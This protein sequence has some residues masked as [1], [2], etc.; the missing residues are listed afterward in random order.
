MDLVDT[1]K[2][3]KT[4]R[5]TADNTVY[6][7]DGTTQILF[8]APRQTPRPTSLTMLGDAKFFIAPPSRR[9]QIIVDGTTVWHFAQI[10]AIEFDEDAARKAFDQTYMSP[11]LREA[12]RVEAAKDLAADEG[13][14][15][16]ATR[17][18]EITEV[19]PRLGFPAALQAFETTDE[20]DAFYA[21]DDLGK[22][23]TYLGGGVGYPPL[24]P[25]LDDD[26]TQLVVR[27]QNNIVGGLG[28]D[29]CHYTASELARLVEGGHAVVV[30]DRVVATRDVEKMREWKAWQRQAPF[31]GHTYKDVHGGVVVGSSSSSPVVVVGLAGAAHALMCARRRDKVRLVYVDVRGGVPQAVLNVVVHAA[32]AAGFESVVASPDAAPPGTSSV[33]VV[34]DFE[35]CKRDLPLL[36]MGGPDLAVVKDASPPAACAGAFAPPPHRFAKVVVDAQTLQDQGLVA[37]VLAAAPAVDLKRYFGKRLVYSC[38]DVPLLQPVTRGGPRV[39]PGAHVVV[40]DT[41]ERGR[42]SE[43]RGDVIYLAGRPADQWYSRGELRATFAVARSTAI[44]PTF[45]HEGLLIVLYQPDTGAGDASW[46]R[47]DVSA[48]GSG[49][50]TGR[51]KR[52][53]VVATKDTD[54]DALLWPRDED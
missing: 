4:F 14:K 20:F 48:I 38:G 8:G 32:L 1:D 50:E 28:D 37:A 3:W 13:S 53:L 17:T 39:M 34:A 44:A 36:G 52:M 49:V 35:A 40:N 15:W 11:E 31:A 19:F 42:V 12:Y 45:C 29:T 26:D 54:L 16:W 9:P 43:V 2:K 47:P 22:C 51:I 27:F 41:G 25:N 46:W 30:G 23:L 6:T 10:E 7:S 5:V 33:V 18:K 21:L 24:P